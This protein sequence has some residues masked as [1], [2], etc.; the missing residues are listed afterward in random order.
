MTVQSASR[1]T[2]EEIREL[3]PYLEQGTC[4]L[5]H[6]AISPLST[7]VTNAIKKRLDIRSVGSIE[8]YPHDKPIIDDCRNQI[9]RLVNAESAERIA[10]VPNTSSGLNI[11]ANGLKWS[12]GD[13][14]LIGDVEFPT[15]VYPFLNLQRLGVDVTFIHN[16]NGIITAEMLE[17]AT[18]PKTK[19]ITISAVQFLSGYRADLKRIGEWCRKRDIWFV[20]DGIQAVGAMELDVVSCHIDAMCAGSHKWQMG[21]Q[22]LGFLYVNEKM[23]NAIH[24]PSAGWLS[25]D[26]PWELLDYNLEF[27]PSAMRYE[28]G[29]MNANGI[30]GYHSSLKL[31]N[32]FGIKNIQKR[33][34]SL[35]ERILDE[36][37]HWDEVK[38][39]TPFEGQRR[40]GIVLLDLPEK[41]DA[42]GL[43]SNLEDEKIIVAVRNGMLRLSPHFY[44]TEQEIDHSVSIIG[45]ILINKGVK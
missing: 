10:F 6:A 2:I 45:K 41:V 16:E 33:I 18:T 12:A 39:L 22:G 15:N 29:T 38:I 24:P 32:E 23:Q 43:I 42:D 19:L 4:Y 37:T 5:N 14:I 30:I 13:Q 7:R 28:L 25:V 36:F 11:I 34:L 27:L 21:P 20:V 9:A 3:F 35:T 1:Q 8:A 40:A 31:I 44:N 17:K 26:A